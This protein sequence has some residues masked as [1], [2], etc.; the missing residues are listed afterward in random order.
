[1][2]PPSQI[3][4]GRRR[5]LGAIVLSGLLGA[6]LLAVAPRPGSA[7]PARPSTGSADPTAPLIAVIGFAAW[8]LAAYLVTAVLVTAAGG[9]PGLLGRLCAALAARTVPAVVRRTVGVAL[10]AGLL[11]SPAGAAHAGVGGA[12]TQGPGVAAAVNLDW[13]A[14]TAPA[15]TPVPLPAAAAAVVV[16][17]GDT[18]WGLTE[19]WLRADGRTP[20]AAAVAASWPSWW[21]ANREAVGADP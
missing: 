8:V 20:T 6:V 10:G 2:T 16:Q 1:M 17:P 18:L 13:P 14:V 19:R 9:V 12:G 7:W 5:A 21:A 15:A 3:R 11:L 4:L